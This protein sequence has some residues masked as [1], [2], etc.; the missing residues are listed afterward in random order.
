[1]VPLGTN[2]KGDVINTCSMYR[3]LL[4]HLL[5]VFL[6]S[7]LAHAQSKPVVGWV[8]KVALSPGNLVVQ[9][10][11]DTGADHSSLNASNLREFERDGRKWV[12]FVVS[13]SYGQSAEIAQ[14]VQRVAMIKTHSGKIQ[15]RDV[16]RLGICLGK[17]YMEA[18]V[19][20]VDRTK[21]DYQMLVGRTFLAGNV[22][23]DPS[24]TFTSEPNC[25]GKTKP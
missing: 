19:N 4:T 1:M 18:D 15:K 24:T 25:K 13:N 11:L 10:K 2:I 23:I 12:K 17:T 8:E 20:L 16:I 21:F 6:A 3:K 14:E 9:A 22:V 5:F 7:A